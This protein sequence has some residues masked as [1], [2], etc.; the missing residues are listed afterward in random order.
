MNRIEFLQNISKQLPQ[1]PICI[2]I[3]VYDGFF[4]K[5]IF[6][7]LSPSKLYLV[8]PWEIG[9]DKNSPQEKYSGSLSHLHTAYSTNKELK[10]VEKIFNTEIQNGTIIL[11]RGFSY[12][13]I[14]EFADQYF[15]FIYIDATHI[16]ESVKADLTMCLP[17][18]KNTGLI[19]GHDYIN[20][21]SFGVI[22]AV[23]E[24]ILQ[25]YGTMILKSVEGDFAIKILE[26][27]EKLLLK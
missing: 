23:D 24:F 3:G 25:N 13:V 17:K 18:L 26:P 5:N 7:I 12:D 6:N 9:S 22:K 21:D 11:K 14:D 19:C 16:Y 1:N 8:D 2:E 10:N 15:D 20:H 4:A 27:W